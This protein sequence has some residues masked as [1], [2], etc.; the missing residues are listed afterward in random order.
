MIRDIEN[1]IKKLDSIGLVYLLGNLMYEKQFV[2][3]YGKEKNFNKLLDFI[4][5]ELV[6]KKV[7][8]PKNEEELY[9]LSIIGEKWLLGY[10]GIKSLKELVEAY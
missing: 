6:S 2:K 4:K 5:E 8:I 9:Y 7:Q 3:D 1:K 10:F